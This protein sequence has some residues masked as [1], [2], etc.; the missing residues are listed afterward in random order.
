MKFAFWTLY[1]KYSKTYLLLLLLH[2]ANI[3]GE[4]VIQMICSQH[5]VTIQLKSNNDRTA[6]EVVGLLAHCFDTSDPTN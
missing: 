4:N 2:Y 6:F 1:L 5:N 3:S